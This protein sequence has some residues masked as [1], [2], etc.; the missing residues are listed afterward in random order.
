VDWAPRQ[1][2]EHDALVVAGDVAGLQ[3]EA[4]HARLR[5][6]GGSVGPGSS[7]SGGWVEQAPAAHLLAAAEEPVWP[8]PGEG[9]LGGRARPGIGSRAATG[10]LTDTATPN[11]RKLRTL[12]STTGLEYRPGGTMMPLPAARKAAGK[13]CGCCIWWAWLAAC[14]TRCCCWQRTLWLRQAGVKLVS[15]KHR[16]ALPPTA[17]TLAAAA[18]APPRITHPWSRWRQ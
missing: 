11:C 15:C 7:V 9:Q 1:A 5:R 13:A 18:P 10:R 17:S 8:P 16:S 3:V 14:R 12:V 2:A 4:P 6:Q